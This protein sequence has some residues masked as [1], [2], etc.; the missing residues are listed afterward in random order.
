MASSPSVTTDVVLQ[1]AKVTAA[2]YH[3]HTKSYDAV[4]LIDEDGI[5]SMPVK[6]CMKLL[7]GDTVMQDGEEEAWSTQVHRLFHTVVEQTDHFWF[8]SKDGGGKRF[9]VWRVPVA[10]CD[11]ATKE[12]H[13]LSAVP[14][15]QGHIRGHLARRRIH[16]V[17]CDDEV[18]A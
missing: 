3:R 11:A 5:R 10:E 1:A 4:T 13:K 12:F 6:T 17:V 9:D 16:P 2:E 14:V 15:I 18:Q 8:V 7:R